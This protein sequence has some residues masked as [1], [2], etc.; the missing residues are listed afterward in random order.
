[1]SEVVVIRKRQLYHLMVMLAQDLQQEEAQGIKG[2]LHCDY[3]AMHGVV[4]EFMAQ[5]DEREFVKLELVDEP[6]EEA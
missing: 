4:T 3:V 1:M 2:P 6:D 5:D